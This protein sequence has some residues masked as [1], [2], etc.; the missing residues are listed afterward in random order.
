MFCIIYIGLKFLGWEISLIIFG[1]F[2]VIDV[3]VKSI[4]WLIVILLNIFGFIVKFN[5]KS[6]KIDESNEIK[7]TKSLSS[8]M[9]Y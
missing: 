8:I 6:K 7:L 3:V 1:V 5:S 9:S 2:L 4:G